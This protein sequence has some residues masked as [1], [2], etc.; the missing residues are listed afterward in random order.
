MDRYNVQ[1]LD[2]NLFDK[3]ILFKKS[4]IEANYLEK[5]AIQKSTKILLTSDWS[6]NEAVKNYGN[7]NKFKKLAFGSNLEWSWNKK[8]FLQNL[9]KKKEQN[10]CN[11]ISIGVSWHRKGMDQSIRITDHMNKIGCK[12][13]LT[14]VGC[15]KKIN[16]KNVSFIKFLNKHNPDEKRKLVNLLKKSHFH[17]L[18]TKAEG[19]GVV[20]LEANSFGLYN[21]AYNVGGVSGAIKNNI[22]GKLFNKKTNDKVIAKYLVNIF[23][24]KSLFQ[25]KSLLS[26]NYY[27]NQMNWDF[28]SKKLNRMIISCL[29]NKIL[30]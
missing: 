5:L 14:I 10:I 7:K 22:S 26:F 19:Y 28:I 18:M 16:N 15:Y 8:Q 11:L 24:K 21:I 17:I 23:E 13:K 6:I 12:T 29:K 30:R 2:S 1:Y 4:F 27:F 20:F 9:K 3:K 25:K